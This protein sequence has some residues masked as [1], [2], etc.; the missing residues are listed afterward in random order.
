MKVTARSLQVKEGLCDKELHCPTLIVAAFSIPPLFVVINY[1]R[2]T[3]NRTV[4]RMY[5]IICA[6]R[7]DGTGQYFEIEFESFAAQ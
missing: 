6:V 7:S 3:L 2:K 5:T 1:R 4:C